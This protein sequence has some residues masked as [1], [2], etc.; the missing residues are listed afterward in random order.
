MGHWSG[1]AGPRTGGTV[2]C[3]A[4]EMKTDRDSTGGVGLEDQ[5][6]ERGTKRPGDMG[7]VYT[8]PGEVWGSHSPSP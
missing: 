3:V 7:K 8:G 5:A 1:A 2:L 4:K 6:D